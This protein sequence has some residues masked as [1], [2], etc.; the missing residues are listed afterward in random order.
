MPLE[1][2][3]VGRAGEYGR[4]FVLEFC[5]LLV[6]LAECHAQSGKLAGR[7]QLGGCDVCCDVL[8]LS[9]GLV[10]EGEEGV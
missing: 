4:L 6:F 2:G 8:Y 3:P 7:V 5:V 9:S 10:F 1:S